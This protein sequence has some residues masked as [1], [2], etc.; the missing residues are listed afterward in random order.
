LCNTEFLE[1][2][3]FAGFA[4]RGTDRAFCHRAIVY[5]TVLSSG[6]CVTR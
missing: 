1:R 6:E 3:D 4:A 2:R 5:G